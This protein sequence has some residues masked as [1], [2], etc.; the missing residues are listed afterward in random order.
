MFSIIF[1]VYSKPNFIEVIRNHVSYLKSK[2]VKAEIIIVADCL[3]SRER[4][5][6]EATF[7]SAMIQS[8]ETR[9][10]K[11][12]AVREGLELAKG[13]VVGFVDCDASIQPESVLKVFETAKTNAAAIAVRN[14]ASSSRSAF[15]SSLSRMFNLLVRLVLELPYFDTQCGLKAFNRTVILPI[16]PKLRVN[17]FAFD[18]ELLYLLKGHI[19]EIQIPWKEQGQ[20][21]LGPLSVARMALD[22]LLVRLRGR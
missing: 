19:I 2:V 5:E 8:S 16:L 18:I 14:S 1:P 4:T 12:R 9:R 13:D 21:A 7:P 3:S 15:R 22:V 6:L 17:G 11:G 20:S 10:G